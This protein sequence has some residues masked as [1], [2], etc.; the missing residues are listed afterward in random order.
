MLD[1]SKGLELAIAVVADP[2]AVNLPEMESNLRFAHNAAQKLE[3]SP[4]GNC[5]SRS[6][7]RH[8][9]TA[10]GCS[11]QDYP[12]LDKVSLKWEAQPR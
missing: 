5:L 7:G 9:Y 2:E 6:R 11:L 3:T 10:Q 1:G 8:R 12:S 4:Q